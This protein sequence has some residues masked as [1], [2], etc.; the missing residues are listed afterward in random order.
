MHLFL[1]GLSTNSG[2]IVQMIIGPDNYMYLVDLAGEW[3]MVLGDAR[4]V[5]RGVTL[6]ERGP[7]PMQG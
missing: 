4:G 7:D 5:R 1:A 6:K 3:G 2:G